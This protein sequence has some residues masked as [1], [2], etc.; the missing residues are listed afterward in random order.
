MVTIKRFDVFTKIAPDVR[1]RTSSGGLITVISLILMFVLV[2]AEYFSYSKIIVRP[3]LIVDKSRGERMTIHLN[4]T[5][6]NIPCSLLSLDV[7]DQS[8][9][10]QQ[11]VSHTIQKTRRDADGHVI[12]QEAMQYLINQVSP[13]VHLPADYCGPCYGADPPKDSQCCNTCQEIRDAYSAKGWAV[14]DYDAF[15]QCKRENYKEQMKIES[16][17]G[18]TLSGFLQVNKVIGNFHFAPGKSFMAQ[19]RMHVHDTSAYFNDKHDFSHTIH[20]LHF[21][22]EDVNTKLQSNPLDGVVKVNSNQNYN[23]VY[24]VKCVSTTY[25]YL[26]NKE[27]TST[28]QYSVTSHERP[29]EGGPDPDHKNAVHSRGGIP[30]VFFS[31]DISP[32]R[33]LQREQRQKTF[34]EFFSGIIA[35]CGGILVLSQLLDRI[36]FEGGKMYQSKDISGKLL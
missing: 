12:E 2:T 27:S 11:D 29:I 10:V 3:E 24:F 6:P 1:I 30:G 34:A 16:H 18:C 25:I 8:G 32:M 5:F 4:I 22:G 14:G 23:Y 9:E 26:S 31:Y 7:M 28:N 19:G 17:E 20:S 35:V 15:E 33:V 13:N 21:G 36:I